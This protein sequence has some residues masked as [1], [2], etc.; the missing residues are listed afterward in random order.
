MRTKIYNKQIDDFIEFAASNCLS[1][2]SV[3]LDK[4]K[5]IRFSGLQSSL[6]N[7][8]IIKKYLGASKIYVNYID[9]NL[10]RYSVSVEYS[11]LSYI[12]G[13]FK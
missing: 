8:N 13:I 2:D 12:K 9:Y 1:V 7:L 5:I 4:G 6:D 10:H 11:L 3:F